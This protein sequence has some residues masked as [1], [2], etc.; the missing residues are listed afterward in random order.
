MELIGLLSIKTNFYN[1][2][3]KLVLR[4]MEDDLT[5]FVWGYFRNSICQSFWKFSCSSQLPSNFCLSMMM[6]WLWKSEES[7]TV[8]SKLFKKLEHTFSVFCPKPC[9]NIFRS[10]KE[11]MNGFLNGSQCVIFDRD[12]T[13]WS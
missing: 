8:V 2:H 10:M 12:F 4:Q 6:S 5:R 1:P 11:F 13:S 9:L 7:C 3:V